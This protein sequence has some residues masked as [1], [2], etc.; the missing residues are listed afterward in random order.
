MRKFITFV[1]L[2]AFAAYMIG[3]AAIDSMQAAQDAARARASL[4]D[5]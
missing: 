2:V 1:A 4:A 5:I 3:H